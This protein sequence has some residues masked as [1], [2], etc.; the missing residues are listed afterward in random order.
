MTRG[1]RLARM[2]PYF[3]DGDLEFGEDFEQEGLEL[4]VGAVYFVNEQDGG[5]VGLS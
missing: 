2:V 3:G 5:L 4:F 1:L